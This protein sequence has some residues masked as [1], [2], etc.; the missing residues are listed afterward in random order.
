M[1]NT[2][3]KRTSVSSPRERVTAEL[4]VILCYPQTQFG[5]WS[6]VQRM[7]NINIHYKLYI[8]FGARGFVTQISPTKCF[9]LHIV[10]PRTST[11][12]VYFGLWRLSSKKNTT[13][14]TP[15]AQFIIN[16]CTHVA[17]FVLLAVKLL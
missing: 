9:L 15:R 16:T 14:Q 13:A 11:E 6:N 1:W 17:I 7:I 12:Q 5:L 3:K 2:V 8:I 10:S 4:Y